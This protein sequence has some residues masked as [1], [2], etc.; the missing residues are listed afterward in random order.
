MT[1]PATT[2]PTKYTV[3]RKALTIVGA[4]LHVRA[5]DDRLLAY[6]EMKAWKLKEDIRVYADESKRTE[7]LSIQARQIIDIAAAYDVTDTP[8]G[9]KVGALRRKG[10]KSILRDEWVILDA[11]EREIGLVQEESAFVAL[12]RRIINLIPQ[13]FHLKVGE[14]VVGRAHQ[15]FNPFI[16][17]LDVD[18]SED[19]KKELDPRLVLAAVILLAAIEGRQG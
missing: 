6:T 5:E 15:R 11:S 8:T 10:L 17:T 2:F 18:T 14:R 4:K 13:S 12:L 19:R 7:L 16:L 3:R 1:T 9:Q